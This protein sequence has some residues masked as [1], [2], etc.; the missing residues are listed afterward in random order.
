MADNTEAIHLWFALT[1]SNYL[2]MP[3]SVLQSM[4][5]E[6]Q[7]RFVECLEECDEA[8]G[9]LDWPCYNVQTLARER[10]HLSCPYI[11]CPECEGTQE[12]DGKECEHCEGDGQVEDPE[13]S[14]YE[15]V[16]EVGLRTDPI[17]HYNRGRTRLTPRTELTALEKSLAEERRLASAAGVDLVEWRARTERQREAARKGAAQCP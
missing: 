15:T 11:D 2:V 8:F 16:E 6:W 3:R 14:R 7:K 1:Y 4:P 12:I 9:H 13:G 17:P 10:E 5:D